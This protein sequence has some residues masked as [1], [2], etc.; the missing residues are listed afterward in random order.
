MRNFVYRLL[1]LSLV[2][3]ISGQILAQEEEATEIE[4]YTLDI[5]DIDWVC[6]EEAKGG[7]LNVYNWTGYIGDD[8]V[9][10][11]EELCDV[12]VT[13]DVYESNEAVIARMRQGNAGYD[14]AFPTDYAVSILIRE[15]L[16]Q[17]ID[18]EKIPNFVHIADEYKGLNFDPENQYSVPYLLGTFGILYDKNR[19]GEITTWEQTFEHDGPVAWTDDGRSMLAVALDLLGYSPNST[20]EDEIAEARDFLLENSGNVVTI[21]GDPNQQFAGGE[22]DIAIVYSGDAY[23]R[24]VECECDNFAY[25]VPASGS[26]VD[27]SMMVL[28]DRAPNPEVA[29]AFMDFLLD[30]FVNADIVNDSVYPTANQAA[31]DTGLISE[32]ILTNPAVWPSEEALENLFFLEDVEDAEFYYTDAWDEIIVGTG[33]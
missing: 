21:V 9:S 23:R 29:I 19:T 31:I 1:V 22:F 14:I 33:Y 7:R 13:Y 10:I 12:T 28:L 4:P 30:P 27:I 16:I 2:M 32:E 3:L 8:T 25:I 11:F 18:L 5:S 17:P 24:V 6:P 20:D 26:V 15:E